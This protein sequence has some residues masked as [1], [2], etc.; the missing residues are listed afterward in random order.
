MIGVVFEDLLLY[1]NYLFINFIWLYIRDATF[2]F[3][4]FIIGVEA[5]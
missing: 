4:S 1:D 3:F 5:E 2:L